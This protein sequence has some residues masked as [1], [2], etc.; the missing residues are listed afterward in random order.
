[1]SYLEIFDSEPSGC[2]GTR[3]HLSHQPLTTR[4]LESSDHLPLDSGRILLHNLS[5]LIL[6]VQGK[7]I[8]ARPRLHS[9]DLLSRTGS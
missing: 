2:I 7:H 4:E 3:L 9:N 1:V 8:G 6:L 5:E